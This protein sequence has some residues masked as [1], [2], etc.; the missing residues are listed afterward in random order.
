MQPEV[1]GVWSVSPIRLPPEKGV[2]DGRAPLP[3]PAWVSLPELQGFSAPSSP[4]YRCLLPQ[5]LTHGFS[6]V[7]VHGG[8]GRAGQLTPELERRSVWFRRGRLR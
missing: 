7:W 1:G 6:P 4:A 3:L 2:R 8:V 5:S